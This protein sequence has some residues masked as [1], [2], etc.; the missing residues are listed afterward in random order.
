MATSGGSGADTEGDRIAAAKRKRAES[1][2]STAALSA[3]TEA[4]SE[5]QR[6]AKRRRDNRRSAA[7]FRQRQRQRLLDAT[8]QV[9]ELTR[10]NL[11]LN[12]QLQLTQAQMVAMAEELSRTRSLS[13]RLMD[14]V[15]TMRNTAAAQRAPSSRGRQQQLLHAIVSQ[16]ADLEWA[17]NAPRLGDP[18]P[19]TLPPVIPQ[20]QCNTT[21]A[22]LPPVVSLRDSL[23][24]M[25]ASVP[26][27]TPACSPHHGTRAPA[28]GAIAATSA[29]S[30]SAVTTTATATAPTPAPSSTLVPHADAVS[31]DVPL[32]LFD[33]LAGFR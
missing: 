15:Q 13:M 2:G 21:P 3:T 23:L 32:E 27:S 12:Q 16:R 11:L 30:S 22:T 10:V 26:V 19:Q 17:R 7:A 4:T 28:S 5:E 29:A 9:A 1:V 25:Q 20:V 6:L 24:R 8:S 18:V 31:F 14:T 33:S